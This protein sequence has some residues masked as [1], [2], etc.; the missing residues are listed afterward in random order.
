MQSQTCLNEK[1]NRILTVP[2]LLSLFRICLI[3]VIVWLYAA[4]KK[5]TEAGFVLLLSGATDLVDGFIARRFRMVSNLGKILD[6]VADKLTQGITLICLLIRFPSMILPLIL[7][8]CKE[9]FMIVTGAMA[10]R[11]TGTVSGAVWHGKIAT[12]LLY[13]MML[14]HIFWPGIPPVLSAAS[15]CSCSLMIGISFVLYLLRNIRMLRQSTEGR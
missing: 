5:S 13:A 10:I 4:E 15:A 8:A 1:E 2:N 7:L 9:L 14:L 6:P 11:K 12:A 3:P